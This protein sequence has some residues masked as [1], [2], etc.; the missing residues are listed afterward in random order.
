MTA[1]GL[2]MQ[3][4]GLATQVGSLIVHSIG[5]LGS[6]ALL[7]AFFLLTVLMTQPMSNAA[8]SLLV[9]PIALSTATALHQNP[10]TFIMT[11]AIAASASFITPLEPACALVYSPG[12]Y[13]FVDFLKCGLILTILLMAAVLILVPIFWPLR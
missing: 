6:T 7:A 10:R 1:L 11:V 3:K 4:T 9:A 5:G 13:K 8:A 2:A 12:K